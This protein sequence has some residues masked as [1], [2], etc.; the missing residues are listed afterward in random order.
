MNKS[1]LV[2]SLL[3]GLSTVQLLPNAAMPAAEFA[4]AL[5]LSAAG[6]AKQV[7]AKKEAEAQAQQAGSLDDE[8]LHIDTATAISAQDMQY[9]VEG[10]AGEQIAVSAA[11]VQ[12]SGLL[13]SCVE[14]KRA[15]GVATGVFRLT[16]AEMFEA[17]KERHAFFEVAI[18]LQHQAK[19]EGKQYY[20]DIIDHIVA[21]MGSGPVDDLKEFFIKSGPANRST[22]ET[23]AD[24]KKLRCYIKGMEA[25]CFFMLPQVVRQAGVAVWCKAYNAAAA[26]LPVFCDSLFD[27]YRH[28]VFKEQF[29]PSEAVLNDFRQSVNRSVDV[30]G[31][32]NGGVPLITAKYLVREQPWGDKINW[33]DRCLYS[34]NGI[35][36]LPNKERVTALDLSNNFLSGLDADVVRL[37]PN[38]KFLNL[39]GNPIAMLSESTIDA[40]VQKR[41]SSFSLHMDDYYEGDANYAKS[42]Q[43]RIK[44]AIPLMPSKAVNIAGQYITTLLLEEQTKEMLKQKLGKY[45]WYCKRYGALDRWDRVVHFYWK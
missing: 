40:L 3:F 45:V 30:P 8:E 9:F 39:S 34:L 4:A 24:W 13:R 1:L 31:M 17:F 29:C 25:A 7:A 11:L 38:L 16:D 2:L 6:D 15:A 33:K 12:A 42:I 35:V 21:G 14:F 43:A 20:K 44:E 28:S 10:P 23:S 19:S 36:A 41:P 26:G 5:A 37:L 27:F 18:A 22:V 32:L